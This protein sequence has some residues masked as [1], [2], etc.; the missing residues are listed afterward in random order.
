MAESGPPELPA[1]VTRLLSDEGP[2]GL[3]FELV[4]VGE[5]GWPHLA[6][7]SAGELL[8]KSSTELR[9]ALHARSRTSGNLRREGRA[10]LHAVVD[11]CTWTIRLE[12]SW[13]GDHR[14]GDVALG[15][16][17]ARVADVTEH[18]APYAEV[19]TG[20]TFALTD[21]SA[22]NRWRDTRALLRRL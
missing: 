2:E 7:L 12:T 18:R 3:A 17:A 14:V 20:I 1:A 13:L 5:S 21:L 16:F 10:L 6:L 4:S 9:V 15:C 11:G 19:V 22:R 8:P